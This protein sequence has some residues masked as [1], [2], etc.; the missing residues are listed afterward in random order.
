MMTTSADAPPTVLV[1]LNGVNSMM[2][3]VDWLLSG[4]LERFPNIKV[5]AAEAHVH[6]LPGWLSLL[7]QQFGAG[8]KMWSA[9]SGEVM[10]K[11]APSDYFRRQCYLAAFPKDT[12]IRE[13][14]DVAPDS[15]TICTD[16]P[17]PVASV[18]GQAKGLPGVA[19]NKTLTPQIAH[20]I[21]YDNPMRFM[22]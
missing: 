1:S 4:I 5:G 3:G 22:A 21:L 20:R 2:A 9:Q 17:H 16:Y 13:A 11:L 18:Y 14:Y 7:D 6:W 10:L 15:I 8:T 19:Q 12:M